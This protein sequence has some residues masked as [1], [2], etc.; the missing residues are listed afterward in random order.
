MSELTAEEERHQRELEA[1]RQQGRREV[2]QVHRDRLNQRMTAHATQRIHSGASVK[3][4]DRW[5][6]KI[7]PLRTRKR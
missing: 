2:E 4:C 3:K 7:P 6:F 5:W 1:V